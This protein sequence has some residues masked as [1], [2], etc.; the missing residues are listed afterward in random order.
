MVEIGSNGER[1]RE[2]G[3]EET[4]THLSS[5]YTPERQTKPNKKQT[6]TSKVT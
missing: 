5:L 4:T 6:R 2:K 3:N 1:E